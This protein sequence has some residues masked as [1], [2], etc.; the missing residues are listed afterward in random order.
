MKQLYFF[1]AAF[2][3]LVQAGSCQQNGKTALISEEIPAT[4]FEKKIRLAGVLLIDVRTPEEFA[5]GHIQGAKNINYNDPSFA[6]EIKKLDTTKTALIYCLAGSRSKNAMTVFA[7][8]GFKKI[9]NLSGGTMKWTASGFPLVS[10]DKVI[11][12]SGGISASDYNQLSTLAEI[13]VID[14]NAVWCQP[15]KKMAPVLEQAENNYKGRLKVVKLDVDENKSITAEKHIDGIPFLEIYKNGKLTMQHEG[16]ISYDE[17][18]K[19]L[20]L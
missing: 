18:V 3:F 8:A 10:E 12:Q 7:E 11:A 20:P 1:I 15:C 14:F 19:L 6:Q 2:F 9:Y 16:L 17:L 13:V 4:D 5:A